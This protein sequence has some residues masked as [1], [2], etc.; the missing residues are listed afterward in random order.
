MRP[1]KWSS[2]MRY[3]ESMRIIDANTGHEAKIGVPFTNINGTLVL[4]EVKEGLFS[5]KGLFRHP[6]D[7]PRCKDQWV[8]LQVR[9]THPGFMLQKVA[10]IPS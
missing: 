4:L 8:P 3:T 7:N 5:A 10:F 6:C 9:Y 1:S 2:E